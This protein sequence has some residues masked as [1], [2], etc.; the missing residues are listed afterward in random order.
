ML[1]P[2]TSAR[3]DLWSQL[4][5]LQN[6]DTNELLRFQTRAIAT[7]VLGHTPRGPNTET[8]QRCLG[9]RSEGHHRQFQ[10]RLIE[11]DGQYANLRA[12]TTDSGHKN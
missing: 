9:N 10:T 2:S 8:L 11:I 12:H 3:K 4:L 5:E 6:Q 1:T 7:R